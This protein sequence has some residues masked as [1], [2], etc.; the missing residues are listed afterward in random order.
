MLKRLDALG[1]VT[2]RRSVA[3]E[4]ST[5]VVLTDARDRLA[6]ARTGDPAG[7]RRTSR[8]RALPS[9]SELRR[10]LTRVNSAALAA[11]ALDV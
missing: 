2:R 1:F 5:H 10:V 9:S 4:R 6:Q 3:D 11:G 8:R 7:R